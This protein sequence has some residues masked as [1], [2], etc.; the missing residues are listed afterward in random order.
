MSYRNKAHPFLHNVLE[1]GGG[2]PY[3]GDIAGT[4][5]VG[6]SGSDSSRVLFLNATAASIVV[7]PDA[8]MDFNGDHFEIHAVGT[9][10]TYITVKDTSLNTLATLADGD[11]AHIWNAR[12][13]Y[14]TSVVQATVASDSD[15]TAKVVGGR[16]NA[17]TSTTDTITAAAS[18]GGYIDFA[19]NVLIPGGTFKA[20]TRVSILASVLVSN[21]AAGTA[22]L[23]TKLSIGPREVWTYRIDTATGAEAYGIDLRLPEAVDIGITSAASTSKILIAGQIADAWNADATAS[24]YATAESDGVDT[25]TFTSIT[26]RFIRLAEDENAAKTTLTQTVSATT[27]VESTAVDQAADDFQALDFEIN[28]IEQPTATS[29]LSGVGSWMTSTGGTLANGV[30]MLLPADFDTTEDLVIRAWGLW[31]AS[32]ATTTARLVF[33]SVRSE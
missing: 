24:S 20:G 29:E 22:T 19:G 28:S 2:G 9:A 15:P 4:Y 32:E 17:F 3:R 7:L 11:E 26:D 27:L 18:A 14:S 30:V 13:S 6:K 12:G 25:V 21:A 8:E 1:Q 5:T 10:G 33:L 23:K 31:S 16:R